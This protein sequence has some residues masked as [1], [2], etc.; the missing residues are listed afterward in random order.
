MA[1]IQWFSVLTLLTW[2][3]IAHS[4]TMAN[5]KISLTPLSQQYWNASQFMENLS[6]ADSSRIVGGVEAVP[7]EFPWH[8]LVETIDTTE[9]RVRVC[10]GSLISEVL[11]LT[12]ASCTY[13]SNFTKGI[14]IVLGAHDLNKENEPGREIK[15]GETLIIHPDYDEKSLEN[16][17]ALIKLNNPVMFNEYISPI[18]LPQVETLTKPGDTVVTAGWGE[19]LSSLM[20]VDLTVI[21]NEDCKSQYTN[22]TVDGVNIGSTIFETAMCTQNGNP[23]KGVCDFDQGGP[24]VQVDS[25]GAYTQIGLTSFTPWPGC[26]SGF[27][28]GFI[29]IASYLDW[30]SAVG[31]YS[32]T[33]SS[34]TTSISTTLKTTIDP[35]QVACGRANRGTGKIIGGVQAEPNEFPWQVGLVALS[36]T[37]EVEGFCGGSLV[38]EDAVLTAAHCVVGAKK[39]GLFLGAHDIDST[40]ETNRV[41]VESDRFDVHPDWND[42]NLKGD[43]ALVHLPDPV[44]FNDYIRPICLPPAGLQ[45]Q[46]GD[47]AIAT[48]WGRFRDGSV[49]SNILRKV[50]LTMISNQ[51]CR[52]VFPTVSDEMLCTRGPDNKGVCDGDSGGPLAVV[53]SDGIYIQI[54]ITSFGSAIGCETGLPNGF[55]RVASYRHW[56]S[57][58]NCAASST[59]L[60]LIAVVASIFL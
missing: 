26:R 10:G 36:S 20:K 23:T 57:A 28:S 49:L 54:G 43:I 17:I 24:L 46:P 27:P 5:R 39:I 55:T 58:S 37:G 34:P 1:I 14:V 53:D 35:G 13:G 56:I 42:N 8:V 32:C 38:S 25:N 45:T 29:R 48:G 50:S 22:V 4:L 2:S 40:S 15:Y 30:I 16:N 12:A 19:E 33:T 41:Y 6:R 59:A 31:G 7:H 60:L 21:S 11:V 18:C 52:T 3:G 47:E 44:T 9:T 51:Q